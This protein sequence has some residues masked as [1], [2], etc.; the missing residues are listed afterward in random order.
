METPELGHEQTVS[1]LFSGCVWM[2]CRKFRQLTELKELLMACFLK[3]MAQKNS[4]RRKARMA[5]S[6]EPL[7]YKTA[8]V[9]SI[10]VVAM[11]RAECMTVLTV[12]QMEQ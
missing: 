5:K 1:A 11:M 4:N 6:L 7:E 9:T 2:S 10:L 12:W 3:W 8:L